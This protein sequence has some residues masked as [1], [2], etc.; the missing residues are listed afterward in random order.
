MRD[1]GCTHGPTELSLQGASNKACKKV[2]DVSAIRAG[3]GA[4][5]CVWDAGARANLVRGFHS[6]HFFLSLFSC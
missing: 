2:V 4:T 1:S 3:Y 6:V 5:K